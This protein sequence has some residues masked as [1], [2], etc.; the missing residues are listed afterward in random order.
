MSYLKFPFQSYW[1]HMDK[2]KSRKNRYFCESINWIKQ[3]SLVILKE[4]NSC[5]NR[6]I[7]MPL[8]SN[9]HFCLKN[10]HNLYI[11]TR[12]SYCW[13][14]FLTTCRLYLPV[15]IKKSESKNPYFAKNIYVKI[16]VTDFLQAE[17]W[18]LSC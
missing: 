13:S 16:I 10:Y 7:W 12:I 2:E 17:L 4:S 1:S 18:K 9:N 5:P 15:L 8:I 6:K 14:N 3:S 11:P